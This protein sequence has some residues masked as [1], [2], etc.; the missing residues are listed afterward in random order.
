VYTQDFDP[1]SSSLGLT[2]IFAALPL[3]ALFLLLGGVRMKAQW[4]ALIALLEVFRAYAP[5]LIIIAIFSIA[6][7]GAV[8]DWLAE[9]PWT[10]TFDWPGLDVRSPD[11]EALTSL[12]FNFNWLPAAGTLMLISGLITMAVLGVR[13]GRALGTYGRTLD[14]LK[15]RSSPSRRCW[16]SPM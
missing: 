5:Y 9:S 16:R 1:V 3:I 12:T 6:Q 13:P 10:T 15:G 7:I 11:G 8:K 2:A 4:A 14:Q